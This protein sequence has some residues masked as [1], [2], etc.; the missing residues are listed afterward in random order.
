MA[1]TSKASVRE[2]GSSS[3]DT[4]KRQ[5]E[6]E[7]QR[8]EWL[9]RERA[10][11]AAAAAD[12]LREADA[13]D[14]RADW[15]KKYTT[16][17]SPTTPTAPVTPTNPTTNNGGGAATAAAPLQVDTGSSAYALA[18]QAAENARSYQYGGQKFDREAPV[19][20][21]SFD[22]QIKQLYDQIN[23]RE[24]FNYDL[25]GDAFWQQYSDKYTQAAKNAMRDTMGQA[26]ALTGG[27]GSSYG[28]AVG[29]QAYDRRMEELMDIA[30][31]LY[32]MAYQRYND[33]GDRMTQQFALARQMADDEYGRYK[34]DY[35]QWLTERDYA[36]KQEQQAYNRFL[37]ERNYADEQEKLAYARQQDNLA[38]LQGLMALG[39]TPTA[40]EIADAGL[41]GAQ[42]Q[43][44]AGQYQQA[45]GGGGG[46]GGNNSKYD[47]AKGL[48]TEEIKEIQKALGVN[49]D[50]VWGS[51]TEKAYNQAAA[52]SAAG[53][54]AGTVANAAGSLAAD[55]KKGKLKTK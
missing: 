17:A 10:A 4:R 38:M 16:P 34:D 40:K 9:A 52:A 26:A 25:N 14:S 21:G 8:E 11:A 27:Y 50:G 6:L 24:A 42:Y 36:D 51:K 20:S 7:D 55:I 39:Y 23:G 19:Y 48:S 54:V 35:S 43:A 46:G 28:Q 15:L 45:S 37:T 22:D 3:D 33:E 41:T 12:R 32:Q 53:A 47:N 49:P 44:L 29:Q 18:Q 5:V 30:P 13:I 1:I 2:I 31:E